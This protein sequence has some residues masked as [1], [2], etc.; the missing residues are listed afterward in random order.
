MFDIMDM[1]NEERDE[2]LQLSTAE[3]ADVARFCNRY[4]NV[5]L[6]YTVVDSDNLTVSV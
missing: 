4:P 1:E 5:D 6:K 2:L 3:M